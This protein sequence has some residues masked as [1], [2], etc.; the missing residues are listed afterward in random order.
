MARRTVRE[1]IDALESAGT[2]TTEQ[3]STL[4]T[5]PQ[6]TV[7][8]NE[9]FA[10]LGGLIASIG[11]TWLTVALVE[12]A[13]PMGIALGMLCAGAIIGTGAKF[14]HRPHSWRARLAEALA[15]VAV[16]LVAGSLGIMVNQ[17]GLASEHAT[18]IVTAVC[19][20][21]GVASAKRTQFAGSIVLVISL[22]IFVASMIGTLHVEDNLVAPLLFV[23]S[24]AAL[25]ILGT[26]HIGFALLPRVVGSASYV[27]GSFTFGVMYDRI[28]SSIAALAL[29][30]ALFAVSTRLLSL[31]VIAGGAIAVTLTTSLLVTRVVESQVIRGLA[32]IIIG[33]AMVLAASAIN[34]RRR[35]A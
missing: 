15:V 22:Q 2:L 34:K 30:L 18:A 25:L 19:V 26:R 7:D 17:A 20:A 6:W 28:P 3:A 23:A 13:S 31:E 5:A 32:I 29:A 33:L 8:A 14:L 24:G 27:L 16:G 4:R 1:E 12:D 10:Y 35:P 11:I 9:L 21:L